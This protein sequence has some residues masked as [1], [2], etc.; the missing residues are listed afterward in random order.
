MSQVDHPCTEC[1]VPSRVDT[2]RLDVTVDLPS[3]GRRGAGHE[4]AR[5][6]VVSADTSA[7]DPLLHWE[8]PSCGYAESEYVDDATRAALT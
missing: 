5:T 7:G 1:H 6:V 8:C 4:P 3:N 2:V